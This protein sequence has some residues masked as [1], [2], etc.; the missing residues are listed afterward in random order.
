MNIQESNEILTRQEAADFL[1]C[2][3]TTIDRIP[4]LPRIKL[5]RGVRFRRS[6]LDKWLDRQTQGAQA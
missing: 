3:V 5:R 2:C 6:D 1:R 4:E